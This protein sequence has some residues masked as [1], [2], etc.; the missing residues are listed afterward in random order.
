[1]VLSQQFDQDKKSELLERMAA[2]DY[3]VG[4]WLDR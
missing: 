4:G 1:M 2:P 3:Q